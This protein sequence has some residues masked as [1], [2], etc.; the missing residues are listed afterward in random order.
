MPRLFFE[1]RN[2]GIL[3][4]DVWLE[5][6]VRI[7]DFESLSQQYESLSQRF[8]SLSQ[9]Y[10]SFSKQWK[11][12]SQ[13]YDSN[14]RL[15]ILAIMHFG[16]FNIQH[17]SINI[18]Y[19][20]GE[21]AIIEGDWFTVKLQLVGSLWQLFAVFVAI[22][23]YVVVVVGETLGFCVLEENPKGLDDHENV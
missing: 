16:Y 19:Y 7:V 4:F 5:F 1:E 17:S 18:L 3:M 14:I 12:L 6:V 20:G 11:S 10:E 15:D 22:T 9:Q 13:K 21:M 23:V 8:E 2:I